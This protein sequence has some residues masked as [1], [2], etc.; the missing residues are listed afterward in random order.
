M[1]YILLVLLFVLPSVPVHADESV[2]N[3]EIE[4]MFQIIGIDELMSGGFE[5]MLPAIGQLAAQ[6]KLDS[7]EQEDLK[8]IYRVWFDEDIDRDLMKNQ[9]IGLYADTFSLEE[10]EE[11]NRFYQTPIGLKFLEKTPEL[12]RLGT[13]IGID[14]GQAK[15]QQ[16]LDRLKP[17]IEKHR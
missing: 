11:L 13:Q 10:I 1:K 4:K 16:L 15:Q 3:A 7:D 5:A 6:L 8:D 12:M 14:E 17:F 2:K 9:M